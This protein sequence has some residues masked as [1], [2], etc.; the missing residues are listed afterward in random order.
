MIIAA[1]G[2]SGK[3][4]IMCEAI[5]Q[6]LIRNKKV[7]AAAMTAKA[8]AVVRG[9][10]NNLMKERELPAELYNNLLVETVQKITKRSKVVGIQDDGETIFL[11]EWKPPEDF[12][13][14]ALFIDELSMV[15]QYISRW[16]QGTRCRV[17]GFGD[18][19][20]LPEV[21]TETLGQELKT[22]SHDLKMP[23]SGYVSGYGIKVLKNLSE[24]GLTKVFRA[25]N[26]IVPLCHELRDFNMT[27]QE[28]IATMKSWSK[29]SQDIDY[30]EDKNDIEADPSWQII[31]F[32]N[33]TCQELNK[34]L[35]IGNNYPDL[36]DKI[37]L[38]DNLN[39]LGIYNGDVLKFGELIELLKSSDNLDEDGNPIV[40]ICLKW[41]G[42]MPSQNSANPYERG[43]YFNYIS[44]LR[45]RASIY[46]RRVAS[47]FTNMAE[48]E[49]GGDHSRHIEKVQDIISKA[50]DEV[51]GYNA[52][53]EYLIQEDRDLGKYVASK[54]PKLPRLYFV[55][56]DYGYAITT[57]KSQGSEYE[58]VCYLL[59]AFN[60]P[61]IY[62]GCSRAKKKL[63]IVNMTKSR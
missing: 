52:A 15:P 46:K 6:L 35:C 10:I 16:W 23:E 7:A 24:Y 20:Q 32:K 22:F 25:D 51:E 59:E 3:S 4:T 9:K 57:H 53:I 12:D 54:A 40:K 60:K 19:C 39:P 50:K 5:Y 14:D 17:F 34:M 27:K 61:L 48:Y 47:I 42:K 29:K 30:S 62:T 2:G 58:N 13:Y 43:F 1:V 55:N 38:F 21:T 8:T 36:E 31:A 28:I 49:F 26:D 18:F 11:N 37:I 41:R 56:A 63:K 45:D 44:Y 33:K